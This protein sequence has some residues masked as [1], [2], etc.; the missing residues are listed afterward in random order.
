MSLI[1]TTTNKYLVLIDEADWKKVLRY[2]WLFN[3][4][5]IKTSRPPHKNLNVLLTGNKTTRHL[6]GNPF[7][8]RRE[9]LC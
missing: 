6:N 8:F 3:Q 2:D 7:D 1:F 9:N 4:G 5:Y